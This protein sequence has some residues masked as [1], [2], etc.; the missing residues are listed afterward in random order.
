MQQQHSASCRAW[1]RLSRVSQPLY[2]HRGLPVLAW[3]NF[4]NS[5]AACSETLNQSGNA[6]E[7][8]A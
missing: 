1:A 8:A 6:I 5:F 2:Y 7:A 4:W 3:L